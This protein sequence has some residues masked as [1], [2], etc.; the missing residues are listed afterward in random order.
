MQMKNSTKNI[1]HNNSEELIRNKKTVKQFTWEVIPT[2]TPLFKKKC[3]KCR[4]SNLYYCSDKFRLN[5]Q[6]KNIDVWLIYK[7][8]KCD[9]TCNI[10]ILSRTKPELIDKELY[11]MFSMNDEET[12]WRYAFDIET[13]R[14]NKMEVDYSNI[15]YDIICENITF[16]DILNIE[17]ELIEFKIKTSFDLNL[18]LTSLI[19]RCFNISSSQLERMLSSGVITV[20]PLCPVNK[21]KI[22]DGITVTVHR[23]NLKDYLDNEK[24]K[25]EEHRSI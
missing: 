10:T 14:R 2:S 24:S 20:C 15:E 4:S 11:H 18:K 13:I 9:T 21:C 5:S 8:T 22:K 7:C 3:S 6:K 23:Q 12:A 25:D 17:E 16:E 1:K 19:R